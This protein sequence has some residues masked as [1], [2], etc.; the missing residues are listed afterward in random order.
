MEPG[1]FQLEY[2]EKLDVW[3]WRL[4]KDGQLEPKP[5]CELGIGGLVLLGTVV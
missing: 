3:C 2:S 1:N 4:E 5:F